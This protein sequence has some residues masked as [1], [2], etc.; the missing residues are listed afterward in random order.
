[1]TTE[2]NSFY[3]MT[4]SSTIITSSSVDEVEEMNITRI[5]NETII[6]NTLMSATNSTIIPT[7]STIADAEEMSIGMYSVLCIKGFIFG[8]IIIGAVLGNALVILAVRR[9]RKLR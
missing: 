6:K 8:F 4:M 2:M 7:N 1:M 3:N 5:S 9:N